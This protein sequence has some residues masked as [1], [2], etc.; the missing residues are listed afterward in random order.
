MSR[1]SMLEFN[2]R[3]LN[4]VLGAGVVLNQILIRAFFEKATSITKLQVEENGRQVASLQGHI[5]GYKFLVMTIATAFGLNG[6]NC[7]ILEDIG[8]K[9]FDLPDVS[10]EFLAELAASA[11]FL[12]EETKEWEEV[13]KTISAQTESLKEHLLF[14][15]DKT[16]ELDICQGQ[17]HGMTIYESFIGEIDKEIERRQEKKDRDEREKSAAFNL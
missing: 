6:S 13:L 14:K 12:I 17:Y 3:P 4:E 5:G 1:A 11:K 2:A 15:A 10:D 8:D 9:P 16:R 7:T